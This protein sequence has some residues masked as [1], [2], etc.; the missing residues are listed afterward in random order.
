MYVP[1]NYSA[2]ETYEAEQERL[3][4]IAYKQEIENTEADYI[5]L[6]ELGG[7]KAWKKR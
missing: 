4:R 1:D 7:N 3:E 5:T 6:T 2:Y